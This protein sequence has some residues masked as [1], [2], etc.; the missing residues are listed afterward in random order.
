MTGT[1]NPGPPMGATGKDTGDINPGSSARM[2]EDEIE[3]MTGAIGKKGRPRF[4]M[5]DRDAIVG[6]NAIRQHRNQMKDRIRD[7]PESL[8]LVSEDEEM[9][10]VPP[11]PSVMPRRVHREDQFDEERIL[12]LAGV[13]GSL[14]PSS[15]DIIS[16]MVK[17]GL[18]VASSASTGV[19]ASAT[20]SD[21]LVFTAANTTRTSTTTSA[22]EIPRPLI[23]LARAKIH[24]PLTLLTTAS[25]R[26]IHADPSCIKMKKGLV[27]DDPK[28]SVMDT[29]S[30][31]PVETSLQPGQFNEA[32]HNF[33]KLLAKVADATIV[34]D[35]KDHRD[36]LIE[37]DD[38]NDMFDIIL[39][40][41]IEIRRKYF[42]NQTLPDRDAYKQRWNEV[43]IDTRMSNMAQVHSTGGGSN[44]NAR[45]HPYG[46]RGDTA[47]PTGGQAGSSSDGRPFRR[48]KGEYTSDTLLC[49]I[50]GRNGHK[51]NNCTHTQTYKNSATICA[52]NDGKVT[53]K[54]NNTIVCISYNLGR[55]HAPKHGADVQHIC[56]VCGSKSHHAAAKSC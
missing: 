50:C 31:F 18:E 7:D 28:R 42:N 56:A 36:F 16:T 13:L 46:R 17:K 21:E 38:F 10:E 51:S 30:G 39:A 26:R 23:N 6:E 1:T 52:W 25:L 15:K 40:F 19:S 32:Y 53:L 14:S 24:V 49:I 43:K 8:E 33:M 34:Q 44:S 45:F 5:A 20:S 54:S 47:P 12:K 41:D 35:F 11:F 48:G 29:A 2:S 55:C 4:D 9:L 22:F 3:Q 37:R 27:M